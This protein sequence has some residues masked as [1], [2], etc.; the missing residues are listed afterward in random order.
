MAR[1]AAKQ[2]WQNAKDAGIANGGETDP[3]QPIVLNPNRE[4][5]QGLP[6]ARWRGALTIGVAEIPCYVLED[7]SRVI[8]RAAATAVLS[9]SKECGLPVCSQNRS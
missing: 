7:G 8:T 6:L 2:R 9:D 5:R 3:Y 1:S 4:Q